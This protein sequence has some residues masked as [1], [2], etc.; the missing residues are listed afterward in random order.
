MPRAHI[1]RWMIA[2]QL[3]VGVLL[4][5]A[6]MVL[7]D[8]QF[9]NLYEVTDSRAVYSAIFFGPMIL[10]IISAFVAPKIE[11]AKRVAFGCGSVALVAIF[12]MNQPKF[13]AWSAAST[14]KMQVM[15]QHPGHFFLSEIEERFHTGEIDMLAAEFGWHIPMG[16]ERKLRLRMLGSALNP[17]AES[18]QRLNRWLNSGFVPHAMG[19]RLLANLADDPAAFENVDLSNDTVALLL[20]E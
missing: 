2:L 1:F 12:T 3:A 9:I 17:R 18:V 14:F 16:S 10:L 19:S 6:N 15:D 8:S 5:I 11:L 4:F 20:G 13:E 7:S